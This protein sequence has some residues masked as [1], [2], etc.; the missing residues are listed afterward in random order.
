MNAAAW[1][2]ATESDLICYLIDCTLPPA[3]EDFDQLRRVMSNTKVPVLV[4][5]TKEDAL[6]RKEFT[7]HIQTIQKELTTICGDLGRDLAP[8]IAISAKRKQSLDRLRAIVS[9]MIPESPWLFPEDE[10]TD[11]PMKFIIAEIIR[12]QAFRQLGEEIPYGLTVRTDNVEA[13][14]R[15]TRIQATIIVNKASH[16]P[17]VIGRGGERI[18]EIGTDARAAL[19]QYYEG[20]IF[21]GLH[22]KT[23]EGWTENDTLIDEFQGILD[24]V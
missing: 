12:E 24:F 11:R 23:Q 18:R 7:T 3:V 17:I 6:I 19:A 5:A 1:R 4:L 15:L 10:I 14:P 22:V 21:L 13:E 2:V 20:A 8:P 16:K 9:R